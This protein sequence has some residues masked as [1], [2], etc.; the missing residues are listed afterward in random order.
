MATLTRIR[1]VSALQAGKMAALV[2]A[3]MSLIFVPILA[4]VMGFGALASIAAAASSNDHAAALPA[5][6]GVGMF[7]VGIIVAP[8]FYGVI[9][10]IVGALGALIY[11]LVAKWVGGLEIELE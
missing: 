6:L 1:R 10:F 7:L 5:A 9:G 8:I 2:Y 4:L 11:N 3:G